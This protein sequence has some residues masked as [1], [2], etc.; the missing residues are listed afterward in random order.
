MSALV[1]VRQL[2]QATGGDDDH[3]GPER[4]D[5][6]GVGEGVVSHLHAQPVELGHPPVDD[7]DEVAAARVARSQAQLST[8]PRHRLEHHHVVV[9]VVPAEL[10]R[11]PR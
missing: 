6:V 2:R 8:R 7:A 5:E 3:L 4:R 1:E 11:A 10:Q 9:V